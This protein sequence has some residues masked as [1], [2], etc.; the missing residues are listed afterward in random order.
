MYYQKVYNLSG[1]EKERVGILRALIND[2]K[3]IL[4][5]EPTGALDS[6]N[7]ILIMNLLKDISKTKLVIVVSHNI[8][9]I[10]KYADRL[11]ELQDGRML[12]V[13]LSYE[14]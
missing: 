9:L 10:T 7:S 14:K 4:A 6:E 2:P 1:G 11:I 3:I 13:N 5:D 8:P 12:R